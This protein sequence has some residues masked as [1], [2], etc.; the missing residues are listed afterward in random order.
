MIILS[1][2]EKHD[3]ERDLELRH[4]VKNENTWTETEKKNILVAARRNFFSRRENLLQKSWA[5]NADKL[6]SFNKNLFHDR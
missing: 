1:K 5:E 6:H 4:E 2:E 3:R